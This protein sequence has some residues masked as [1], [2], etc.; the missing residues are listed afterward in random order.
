MHRKTLQWLGLLALATLALAACAGPEGPEGPAGP[1]GPAGPIG[2]QG[3]PGAAAEPADIAAAGA[4]YVG[5]ATCGGCH[6]GTYNKFILSGHPFKLNKVVDGQPPTY[7]YTEVLEVP[8]GF[9][10]DDVTYVIG[11][12]NWKARFIG[13]DGYIITGDA[14][15][16]TQYN[17][18]NDEVDKDAGWAAYHPGE[19]KPYDCGPC[20]TTGYQPSG[21]QDGLEGITGTWAEP[22]VQCERCHGPGGN[23]VGDPYGVA[24]EIDRSA[25]LCGDCHIRGSVSAVNAKGGFTR[26]H[27][28]AE[29]LYASK[30]FA[31]G[32][33]GCH[34][35][36]A[37]ALNA[38]EELNPSKGIWNDCQDCHF[39]Q[40]ANQKSST[41][42]GLLSCTDCHMPPMSK[43]AWGNL[44]VFTADVRS[45]LF[46]INDDP[47]APQFS[48]DGGETMPYLTIQYACQSCHIAGATRSRAGASRTLEALA[49]TAQGYHSAP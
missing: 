6:E 30:H 47:A 21:H 14:D 49:E 32:C 29:E 33:V 10:W 37:S 16:T 19:Q 7:P 9:T 13:L 48:E 3:P 41:M 23:H 2:P 28:Q 39:E 18:P 15:A 12:Y 17:F 36:H 45:H 8:E 43:S 46:A 1:A 31:I 5:S 24:M 40:A 35:P 44:D 22:G 26:H 4:D 42:A 27:E 11:G 34:D 20:H 25:Q 38:D